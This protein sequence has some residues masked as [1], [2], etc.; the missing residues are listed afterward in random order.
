MTIIQAIYQVLEGTG[1][2]SDDF[3]VRK[4]FVYNEL[5]VTSNELV[6]QELNKYRLWDGSSAQTLTAWPFKRVDSSSSPD[7][8]TG[9][10][11]LQSVETIPQFIESDFGIA[12]TNVY[13]LNGV[14]IPQIK[15]EDWNLMGKRRFNLPDSIGFF[16]INGKVCVVGYESDEVLLDLEGFFESP[17]QVETLNL[18]NADCAEDQ[19]CKPI[20]ELDFKCP[21][22]LQRRVIEIVRSV[23]FRKLGIPLDDN[24]N[25]K[26]DPNVQSK[27]QPS[28]SRS[29]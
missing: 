15:R 18:N 9:R 2:S 13:F 27:A 3:P 28:T 25:A 21:G 29:V 10:Y 24:N 4:R 23:V 8:P 17:E 26:F 11:F 19:K 14:A 1:S 5:R 7:C 20:F 16:L 6:K 22:H 12:I